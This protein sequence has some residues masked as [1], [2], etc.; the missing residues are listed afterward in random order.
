MRNLPVEVLMEKVL[1]SEKQ[2]SSGGD[3]IT[4]TNQYFRIYILFYFT[5]AN[6]YKKGV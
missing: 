6:Q 4:P 2:K 3:F 5:T 1:R